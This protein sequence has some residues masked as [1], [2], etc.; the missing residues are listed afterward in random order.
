MDAYTTSFILSGVSSSVLTS[1][2]CW[3]YEKL[4]AYLYGRDHG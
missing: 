2:T 4:F 1:A 3:W